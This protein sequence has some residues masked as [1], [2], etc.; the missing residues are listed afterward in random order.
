M[1]L[2]LMK[3]SS[4][5]SAYMWL[6][7]CDLATSGKGR[8]HAPDG[9]DFVDRIRKVSRRPRHL[10][11]S[12]YL[13]LHSVQRPDISGSVTRNTISGRPEPLAVLASPW[14]LCVRWPPLLQWHL[15]EDS[16][17]TQVVHALRDASDHEG[18]AE[19]YQRSL[20]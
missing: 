17:Q 16:P 14:R 18:Q 11:V 6:T 1:S 20:Q 5:P 19:R 3:G 7:V 12:T 13:E 10:Y 4:Q 15:A 9:S 2:V 8:V